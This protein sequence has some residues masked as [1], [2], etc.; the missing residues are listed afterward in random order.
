[1]TRILFL[2]ALGASVLL[3]GGC[4]F[5]RKPK[6]TNAIAAEVAD[7]FRQRWVDQRS[8]QLVGQ[9]VAAEAA[10]AQATSEFNER[11]QYTSPAPKK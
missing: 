5:S 10:R 1:M 8:A 7:S 11:F 6:E 4:L 2:S 3:S 9:G